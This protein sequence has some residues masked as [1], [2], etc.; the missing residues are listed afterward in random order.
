MYSCLTIKS[1]IF[2][3]EKLFTQLHQITT[4]SFIIE[5]AL[6]L[7]IRSINVAIKL[8]GKFWLIR[9]HLSVYF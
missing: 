3:K 8:L 6:F 7:S 1:S 2:L 5:K 9:E 4:K